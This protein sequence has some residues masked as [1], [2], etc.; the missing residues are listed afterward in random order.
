[1]IVPDLMEEFVVIRRRAARLLLPILLLVASCFA[2]SLCVCAAQ[3]G[4]DVTGKIKN[5]KAR[6][7][8]LPTMLVLCD[9]ACNW[10]LD[11]EVQG[12]IESGGGAKV[13]VESGEH[14]VE[15]STED[16]VDQVKLLST[17]K[18]TGQTLISIELQPIRDQRI[19]AYNQAVAESNR[20]AQEKAAREQQEE[21]LRE[22]QAQAK[23][24]L[25]MQ[26]AVLRE[27][28]TDPVTG[29]MWTKKDNGSDLSWQEA[30]DYCKN[31]QL[32]DHNDWR[33]PLAGEF[34]GIRTIHG[35]Y[36]LKGN[37]QI[38]FGKWAWTGLQL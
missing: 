26:Q 7:A 17:V 23:Q 22:R 21:Q 3:Q 9:L 34:Q 15:A 20:E 19:E 2:Y 6:S 37:L 1:M 8:T 35:V 30:V 14:M 16:G 27:P 38:E 5:A 32:A 18:P 10:K 28:W 36:D 25:L 13:K 29:L 24:A 11:G 33:L 31:L 12:H 4:S